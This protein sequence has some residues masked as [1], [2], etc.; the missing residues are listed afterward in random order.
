M[1]PDAMVFILGLGL[2]LLTLSLICPNPHPPQ[3]WVTYPTLQTR[4]HTRTFSGTQLTH[5]MFQSMTMQCV[6]IG[7]WWRE[8]EGCACLARYL[9][10]TIS[11]I[12]SS[13]CFLLNIS[14]YS[15]VD[16]QLGLSFSR[17]ILGVLPND[18]TE[19]H[20]Y[21]IQASTVLTD[22][23]LPLPEQ[24][25]KTQIT[26]LFSTVNHTL[27]PFKV[28]DNSKARTWKSYPN[29]KHWLQRILLWNPQA[30]GSSTDN[31][32]EM[33]QHQEGKQKATPNGERQKGEEFRRP[34]RPEC[35]VIPKTPAL[36]NHFRRIIAIIFGVF[37]M[38]L[39][40]LD[41]MSYLSGLPNNRGLPWWLRW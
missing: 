13:F 30:S 26:A 9:F 33:N 23:F 41:Y 25:S 40:W 6:Q 7:N 11:G 19:L 14:L 4:P 39:A 34:H 24:F 37:T 32:G 1:G 18:N 27:H 20:I 21:V 8:K 2:H 3:P 22:N 15:E 28:I 35:P 31:K 36:L 10:I 5:S 17:E 29:G 12:W 38:G 16:S